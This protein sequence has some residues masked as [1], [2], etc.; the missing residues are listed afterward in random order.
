MCRK[1]CI[2]IYVNKKIN[3]KLKIIKYFS[4]IF[5]C[6]S[7]VVQAFDDV[8]HDIGTAVSRTA[9]DFSNMLSGAANDFGNTVSGTAND[10]GNTMFG[11][12][13]D[14]WQ[15]GVRNC[16][17]LA[18]WSMQRRRLILGNG[19]NCADLLT[20]ILI[21][22][23]IE[24]NPYVFIANTMT[25]ENDV[26]TYACSAVEIV[27]AAVDHRPRNHAHT[28][29]VVVVGRQTF[30]II[31]TPKIRWTRWMI[32]MN[33]FVNRPRSKNWNVMMRPL[34]T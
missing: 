34:W 6:Y 5:F 32:T 28:N 8:L 3:I 11:T 15:Y 29:K 12:T 1:I 14:F 20:S 30:K 4:N 21:T 31:R 24:Y 18:V 17:I 13:K 16:N 25:T 10:F 23:L 26:I 7:I 2:Y 33:R 27:K 19:I 9:N 22:V